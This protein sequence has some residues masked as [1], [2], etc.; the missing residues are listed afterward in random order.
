MTEVA[1]V[2]WHLLQLLRPEVGTVRL[3]SNEDLDRVARNIIRDLGCDRLF[4]KRD[5]A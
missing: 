2:K 4:P 5:A 1:L 3:P